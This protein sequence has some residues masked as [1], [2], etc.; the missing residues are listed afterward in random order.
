MRIYLSFILSCIFFIISFDVK[1]QLGKFYSTDK[2]LS[3]SLINTIY[4]DKKGFIWIATE[5]GLNKFDG[6]KFNIYKHV[7][8]DSTSIV[9]NY[10]RCLLEDSKGRF[11][12][13]C[14][15]AV[16]LYDRNTDSFRT[17]PFRLKKGVVSPHITAIIERENKE[18]WISTLGQG[19]MR[20]QNNEFVP[21][22]QLNSMIGS[23]FINTIYKDREEKIWIS[24]ENK[25]L[26]LYSPNENTL[27][28]F[29]SPKNLTSDAI[30]SFCED[31]TGQLFI[32]T[33]NGG[34]MTV[35]KASLIFTPVL[36]KGKN[37]LNIK[38]LMADSKNNLYIGTEGDGMKRYDRESN[39]I[40]DC[41][42]DIGIFDLSLSKVHSILEDK[43]ENL[44][45]GIFQ[46][47]L[48]FTP[49]KQN[50][51]N[52]I[53]YKAYNKNSIG[54]NCVMAI[55][56]DEKGTIWVGTD[57]D[58]LYAIDDAGN[59]L[60]HSKDTGN[61]NLA[62]SN[63]MCLLEDSQNQLWAGS[64]FSG[65]AIIDRSTGRSKVVKE[66][67]D[68]AKKGRN[69]KIFCLLED[70]EKNIWVG[71]YGSGIYKMSLTQKILKHYH[72]DK[73]ESDDWHTN[74]LCN[75]WVN[76]MIQDNK[77]LLWIG[78]SNGLGCLDPKK[79]TFINF[80]S[81]NNLLP[82]LFVH[83]LVQDK[84]DLIWIGT[85][86]GLYCFNKKDEKLTSYTIKDG[87]PSNVICGIVED[88]KGNLWISTHQGISKLLPHTHTFI[89]YY[90]SDG[91]QGNEFT[92]GAYYK[93]QHGKVY[94][95]G[96][97]GI[98]SFYPNEITEQKKKIKVEITDF[99]LGN[100][101][102]KKGDKSGSRMITDTL[103]MDATQ[104]TLAYNYGSFSLEFSTLEYFS[105]EKIIYQYKIEGIDKEWMNT[106]AGVNR[107]TY[108][109][110][111]PGKY[112]FMVRAKANESVS[113]IRKVLIIITPPW[114][115]MGWATLIWLLLA[116]A[117]LYTLIMYFMSRIRRKQELTERIHQ[118]EINEAKLQFFTNISHEIRTP[119]T[120]IISPLE[121]LIAKGDRE[122]QST[123]LM[124]YRNAQRILRLINQL[125]DI[126]KLDK[127]QMHLKFRETDMV[128]FI[129]NL[130]QTFEYQS[131]QKNITF[132][133]E[134]KM[135]ELKVWIDLN[136]FDKIVLNVLSNAFKYTPEYG[137]I[138]I[139]LTTGEDEEA[140]FPLKQYV[141]ITISDTGIG[142]DKEK[143][144][145]VF[146]RFYQINNDLT[147][148]NFGTGI[149]LHLSRSLIELH[150]GIIRAENRE[151]CTGTRFIIRIPLGNSHLK[152]DELES[153]N[154]HATST[155]SLT[156]K[157]LINAF[158]EQ[159]EERKS[160]KKR[161]KNQYR[162]VV[163]ED[164]DEIRHYISNELENDFH[165][166][167]CINGK[168]ALD[169]ILKKKPDLIISDIMM[170]EMD[171]MTLCK[172]VKQNININHIPVVLLTAKS[173]TE[174]RI[175]GLET[176]A[177]AYLI[178]PFNMELLRTTLFNLIGNRKRLKSQQA[179]EQ[180][181]EKKMV[182]TERKSNDEILL[183][184][185]VKIVNE[186][187]SDPELNVEMLAASIGLSRVHMHRK[188]K[189][190]TNQSTKDF[191]KNIRLKQA[192]NL[193]IENNLTVSEV[194][195]ATGFSTISHF[196]N[197]FKDF[198]GVSP[199][200]YKEQAGTS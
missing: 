158:P 105:P 36:Y 74:Q 102:V 115:Q 151:E 179:N 113:D 29:T 69:E 156:K 71:T 160:F 142:I 187:I 124:I 146:E 42:V 40:I 147:K 60:T 170:P 10:V 177:D 193:L 200:E 122:M 145:Q 13:T 8:D 37:D 23:Y 2:E 16:Q 159:K 41:P 52:Y 134:H 178:K 161:T 86:E 22:N 112:T 24:T 87:L 189:E 98:T 56:R 114:Y 99:M 95:G 108:T 38:T 72:S 169:F 167:E 33:I 83:A 94:F 125:M 116:C 3:N 130:M 48:L 192:A 31:R 92:R 135:Q 17:V 144:E 155:A 20:L 28:R 139:R 15:N 89:N 183:D 50:K 152:T 96:I 195:Y 14:V 100:H 162:I 185:I 141:E 81:T 58:G 85:S 67:S 97:S 49:C 63:I 79:E 188:M 123:Y 39:Q 27:K 198:Y 6:N 73:T 101:S 4:Q 165:I 171:G 91:L 21:V 57:N 131:K 12:V 175:E 47:G 35:N 173:Q 88:E 191:I 59:Q 1:A 186:R 104:F 163:V 78:T 154:D 68:R 30:S 196:S 55:C 126:R 103:V 53:G 129:N 11:W 118:E 180:F 7:A 107:V 153:G 18:I 140:D 128:G 5:D 184:K 75:D 65:L 168:E 82:R 45:L 25:G 44:W 90:A 150:H 127:G 110:L 148:S 106:N 174:D 121:K 19:I 132:S 64:Y 117:L 157:E 111:S 77:G 172:K 182:K 164:D 136:N 9:T 93:D 166:S 109:S 119:M 143:I 51:F 70:G 66:L 62:P 137:E 32:G 176:G 76:C 43:D 61:T 149:G 120:L 34:L 190:M 133:F 194:A 138:N 46:K 181:M 26:F 54:S 199:T 197:S 80:L 84:N